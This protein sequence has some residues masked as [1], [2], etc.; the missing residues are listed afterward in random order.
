[1]AKF[2]K[3]TAAFLVENG[4]RVKE[5]HIINYSGGFYLVKFRDGAGMRVKEHRLFHTKEEAAKSANIILQEDCCP[6]SDFSKNA[7]LL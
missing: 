7:Q 4:V 3:G 6:K 5:V 2:E 1:M